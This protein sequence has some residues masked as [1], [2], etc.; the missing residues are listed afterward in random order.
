[1]ASVEEAVRAVAFDSTGDLAGRLR[2]VLHVP[3]QRETTVEGL[4][5]DLWS[6]ALVL[7]VADASV[8]GLMDVVEE[9][10]AKRPGVNVLLVT[11]EPA[12][13]RLERL[14]QAGAVDFLR[15]PFSDKEL[16][17]RLKSLALLNP[18]LPFE[19]GSSDPLVALHDPKTGR[20]DAKRVAHALGLSVPDMARA[21]G[22]TPQA[23]HK[24]PSAPA[25]QKPL[26]HLRRSIELLYKVY[27]NLASVR[28]WLNAPQPDLAGERP[29]ELVKHGEGE[30]VR[31]FLEVTYAGGPT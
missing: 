12:A 17:V 20:I 31:D 18:W 23:L 29:I 1:M 5:R 27:G 8:E 3:V 15:T 26:G 4:R 24:T 9:L 14:L 21:L 25:I 10:R 13:E 30:A 7:L 11:R 22:R 6:A 28:A 2:R 16:E 19:L